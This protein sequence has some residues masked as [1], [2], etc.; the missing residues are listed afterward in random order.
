MLANLDLQDLCIHPCARPQMTV[1]VSL[2]FD[3]DNK[4]EERRIPADYMDRSRL[5]PTFIKRPAGAVELRHD[6]RS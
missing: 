3:P 6:F 4:D 1:M 5:S 2:E